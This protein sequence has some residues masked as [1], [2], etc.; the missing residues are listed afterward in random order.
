MLST[1]YLCGM[2]KDKVYANSHTN[3]PRTEDGVGKYCLQFHQHKST[4]NN[5]AFLMWDACL[6]SR[7]NQFQRLLTARSFQWYWSKQWSHQCSFCHCRKIYSIFTLCISNLSC[8]SFP[9][10]FSALF[11]KQIWSQTPP[12]NATIRYLCSG[13]PLSTENCFPILDSTHCVIYALKLYIC[14]LHLLLC[15]YTWNVCLI[16]TELTEQLRE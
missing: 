1:F 3:N 2:F 7:G 8:W 9:L 6:F 16:R 12:A 13:K 11:F 5:N 15:P 14:F 10:A 4:F